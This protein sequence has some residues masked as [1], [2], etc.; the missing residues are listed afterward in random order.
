MRRFQFYIEGL[1]RE[2]WSKPATTQKEALEQV[3]RGLS[4]RAL[5]KVEDVRCIDIEKA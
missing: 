5:A 1:G 4:S 2:V 3:M